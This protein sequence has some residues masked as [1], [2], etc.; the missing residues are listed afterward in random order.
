VLLL[1]GLLACSERPLR[2][3]V[4]ELAL[5]PER[6]E[7][8]PVHVGAHAEGPLLLENRGLQVRTL[9]LE[10]TPPFT[11]DAA[12]VTLAPGAS[13]RLRVRYTPTGAGVS[14]GVL[15]LAGDGGPARAVPLRGE[16][17][18]PLRCETADPC[19]PVRFDPAAG[20]C[21]RAQAP[22]GTACEGPCLAPGATCRA[23]A[24]VGTPLACDDGNA[25]TADGC[26]AAA[27]CVHTAVTC[28]EPEDPCQSAFCD[29][30]GGCGVAPAP[31][32]T[33]CGRPARCGETQAE[34][35][36]AG[37]C[38]EVAVPRDAACVPA[39]CSPGADGGPGALQ[40]AWRYVPPA[41]WSIGNGTDTE[42]FADAAGNLYWMESERTRPDAARQAL[43]SADKTGRVRFR[44]PLPIP[45]IPMRILM[46]GPAVLLGPVWGG[47]G[48]AKEEVSLHSAEDGEALWRASAED[49]AGALG[50]GDGVTASFAGPWVL[51]SHEALTGWLTVSRQT[52]SGSVTEQWGV[53]LS[54]RDGTLRGAAR[55]PVSYRHL[56]AA[57]RDGDLYAIT[58]TDTP[59]I[60]SL[61]PSLGAQWSAPLPGSAASRLAV[62]D[63]VLLSDHGDVPA[64]DA[65]TGAE[66]WPGAWPVWWP[67]GVSLQLQ[68]GRAVRVSGFSAV[69]RDARTGAQ[70][71]SRSI[72]EQAHTDAVLT[73]SGALLLGGQVRSHCSEESPSCTPSSVLSAFTLRDGAPLWECSLHTPREARPAVLTPDRWTR[74]ELRSGQDWTREWTLVSYALPGWRLS[75]TGWPQAAGGPERQWR[76]RGG[77]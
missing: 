19:S 43:L 2:P 17:L 54:P 6:L 21:V 8:G 23:G 55:L 73:E 18:A 16:A 31:D 77:R 60:V 7:L 66:L 58:G 74:W 3:A 34:V 35:C 70:L 75:S 42:L 44:M 53:R 64:L 45:A 67:S 39:P 15:Q 24:C 76:E 69:A 30:A 12:D 22:D 50:L 1:L 68:D 72:P 32:G 63:G 27:G 46:V 36:L 11:A 59:S 49:I 48:W 26:S 4:A 71:W 62:A 20:A 57:G 41:P 65:S 13:R 25:C 9:R 28:A 38:Q 52:G 61:S 37:R 51:Q 56:A 10:L 29:R 14:E 40:E 33:S 47:G 5:S